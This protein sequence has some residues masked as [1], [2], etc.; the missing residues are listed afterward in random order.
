METLEEIDDFI[1]DPQL[2]DDDT[3]GCTLTLIALI[4]IIGW[5]FIGCTLSIGWIVPLVCFLIAVLC[6]FIWYYID[7][8]HIIAHYAYFLCMLIFSGCGIFVIPLSLAFGI[9]TMPLWIGKA[10]KFWKEMQ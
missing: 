3:F 6:G 8:D 5:L 4:G 2:A 9:L 7:T 1:T 10:I